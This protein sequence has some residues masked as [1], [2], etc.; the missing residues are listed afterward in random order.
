MEHARDTLENIQPFCKLSF[1][2]SDL[3][4]TFGHRKLNP[5]LPPTMFSSNHMLGDHVPYTMPELFLNNV[6]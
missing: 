2:K 6:H 4:R 5:G 3:I 1:K